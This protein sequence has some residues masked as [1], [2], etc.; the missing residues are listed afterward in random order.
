MQS[1]VKVRNMDLLAIVLF[2]SAAFIQG[3]DIYCR[4][5]MSI[6]GPSKS[7]ND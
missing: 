2:L 4:N 1:S 3:R 7:G 5:I 6:P